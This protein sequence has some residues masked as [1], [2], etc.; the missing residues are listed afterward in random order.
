MSLSTSM[1]LW[2][3]QFKSCNFWFQFSLRFFATRSN[4]NSVFLAS[5]MKIQSLWQQSHRLD[6]TL[7]TLPFSQ[8]RNGRVQNSRWALWT[9]FF[10]LEMQWEFRRREVKYWRRK[11]TENEGR[12]RGISCGLNP[13]KTLGCIMYVDGGWTFHGF[14]NS[15]PSCQWKVMRLWLC[16]CVSFLTTYIHY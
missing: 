5:Y 16:R 1:D 7:M 8:G 12:R 15:L 4:C 14:L 10:R 13:W 11:S 9:C 3:K 2:K 6:T